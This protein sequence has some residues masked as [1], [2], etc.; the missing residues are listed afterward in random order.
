MV[1]GSMFNSKVPFPHIMPNSDPL[2]QAQQWVYD[3]VGVLPVWERNVFGAGVRVRIND[4]GVDTEV[5]ELNGRVDLN[6]SCVSATPNGLEA[7]QGTWVASV[8]GASGNIGDCAVGIA[9][10][11][12]FSSCNII[13][14]TDS[15]ADY[16]DEKLDQFDISINSIGFAGCKANVDG[17]AGEASLRRLRQ[18]HRQ[19]QTCPFEVDGATPC[20]ICDFS[21][22]TLAPSAPCADAI[23][24]HCESYFRDERIC[25]DFLDLLLGGGSCDFNQLPGDAFA[26]P[27]HHEEASR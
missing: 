17:G 14:A 18:M 12:T 15:L 8:L 5:S 16:L 21:D 1:T 7:S 13:T 9:P 4:N 24:S 22:P 23:V 11:V 20:S 2:Y 19:L 27:V 26:H 10:N 3:M 25:L 6:A